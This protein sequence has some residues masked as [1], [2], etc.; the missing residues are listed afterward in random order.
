MIKH[1]ITHPGQAHADDFLSVAI[2]LAHY[3][4]VPVYRRDPTEEELEDNEVLVLD[5]GGRHEPERLN[6]DHHQL[7][8]DAEAE[9]A[10][11]LFVRYL[12]L[13][14][15]FKLQAAWETT[16][17][18]DAKGPFMAAKALGLNT[19]PEELRSFVDRTMLR[20][21]EKH[22]VLY[23]HKQ[24][25]ILGDRTPHWIPLLL[26]VQDL[27]KQLLQ[28]VDE[29]ARVYSRVR[30]LV[31]VVEVDDLKGFLVEEPITP[32]LTA[33]VARYRDREHPEIVFSVMYGDRE[34]ESW[35]LYRYKDHPRVDFSRLSGDQIV[36]AHAGGFIAKLALGVSKDEALEFVKAALV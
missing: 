1:I 27:G 21:F 36:F 29:Y 17:V 15:Q 14:E 12:G 13:E 31:R 28:D 32:V 4:C 24:E 20:L 34:G 5:T 22:R 10:L 18:L 35:A 25:G 23:S 33:A 26:V 8:R 9:C 3:G 30:E 2:A 16:K 19:L 6:F 11:S 7:P